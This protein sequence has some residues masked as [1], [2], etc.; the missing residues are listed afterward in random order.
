MKKIKD[1]LNLPKTGF[2]MKANLAQKEPEMI[3]YWEEIKLYDLLQS[4][5]KDGPNFLLHDGPPYANG[6]IHLGTTNNKVLK[7]IIIKFKQL[8]GFNSPYI[9]GWDCHG[10]PIELNVEKKIGKV[11]VEVPADKFREECREY[12]NQQIAIQRNDF[13]RLGIQADWKNP[14]KTMS[15]DYEANTIRALGKIIE[16]NHLVRGEKPVYW[17]SECKSALAEAEVEYY[18]KESKAIDFLFPMQKEVLENLLSLEINSPTFAASW[19]TTPWTIPSNQA[20]SFNPE[21]QYELIEFEHEKNQ[22]AVLV[23]STLKERTLE[24]IDVGSHNVLGKL[25]GS[26]LNEIEANHPFL[27]RRSL[28]ISGTHV[29]DEMGTGLVHTAPAHGMD[30]YHACLGKDLDFRSP[31]DEKGEFIKSQEFVG[32]LNLEEANNTII[33]LLAEKSLLL[34]KSTYR[35][36]FPNCWR[37]KIP[38]FFRAT[39]QWFISMEKNFLLQNSEEKI[40]EINWLPEWGKSRIEGMMQERPD[41]CI[42]RQRSWG[43]PLPLFTNKETGEL[44][45]KTLEIIEKVAKEVEKIGIQA[46]YDME[47]SSLIDDYELYEKS[48]DILDVWFDSGVTHHCVL[49]QRE[50]LSYPADLYLEGS[51][52]HRGWFQSSLLTGMAI[53]NEAPYRSV[54]THGF[55]VDGEGKKQS[56]S[57]GNT[58]SP[59][60]VWNKKGADIL[61]AW[62]ASSDF[63]NEIYFSDEILDRTADSYR[64]IRNTIR[65]LLSNLYDFDDQQ[66]VSLDSRVEIDIWILKE[67]EKLQ[68]EIIEDY[69]NYEFHLVYQKILNFCTNELGSFY[70]DIL[71]DRL[72]T[73][74]KSGIARI[75]AQATIKSLLD[76]LLLWIAPILSFTAEEAFREFYKDKKSIFLESFSSAQED[77]SLTLDEESWK[78]LNEIK[79]E[80]NKLL[81]EKRNDGIIGSSL[82]AEVKIFCNSETFLRL[83]PCIDELKFLLIVSDASL[84]VADDDGQSSISIEVKSSDKEKCD[85]CWHHTGKLKKILD[86]S[87][88]PRCIENVEGEGEKRKFF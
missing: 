60:S 47:P 35:H 38:V 85:R 15:F 16:A 54:L 68:N 78:V 12:A 44:H 76:K 64:R 59:Q 24:R 82:D 79:I 65:F 11:N 27:K 42:S 66:E 55:V 21:F 72:Y 48:S 87:L 1:T 40:N 80:A 23:A 81:E 41:W 69:S 70:L 33:E 39:P 57:L 10:L 22:I 6:P 73:S 37:H 26:A 8:Q 32:G 2:S 43:V 63:R 3:K 58:V 28:F 53:N 17:C 88:C 67:A 46:W 9:P 86:S 34:S 74:K 20:I 25:P 75:S 83:S 29:T 84:E 18:D 5:N 4:K 14:Y 50:N 49:E 61:R 52:Q 62:V 7:D 36:S 13:K 51:D 30:D 45:P 77:I 71:K 31:V 56:K 19:T